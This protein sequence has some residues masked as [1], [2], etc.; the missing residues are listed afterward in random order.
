MSP[1]DQDLLQKKISL[2]LE[3]LKELEAIHQK[4]WR[5]YE[6]TKHTRKLAER[7]VQE[8]IEA[9]IDMNN[10]I[11]TELGHGPPHDYFSSFKKMGENNI[12]AV[13]LANHLAPAASLRN[14]IVHQYDELDHKIIFDSLKKLLE[15]FPKYLAAIRKC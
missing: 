6:S 3:N 2:I 5:H 9:A 7:F 11:L 10:H 8:T 1:V 4:G 13:D 12:L 15:L 14:R